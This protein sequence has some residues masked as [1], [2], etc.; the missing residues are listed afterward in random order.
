MV[1][2]NVLTSTPTLLQHKLNLL[3][4]K[5]P[6]VCCVKDE[7]SRRRRKRREGKIH[8]VGR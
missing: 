6:V 8:A 3:S 1:I 7:R 5:V 4:S 2:G